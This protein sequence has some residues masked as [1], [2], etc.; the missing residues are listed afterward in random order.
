MG[1]N[2]SWDSASY[3]LVVVD[4]SQILR[5]RLLMCARVL[6]IPLPTGLF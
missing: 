2:L 6:K 5:L 1:L 3:Y 4:K